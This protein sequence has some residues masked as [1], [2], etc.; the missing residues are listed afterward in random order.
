MIGCRDFQLIL[1][2]YLRKKCSARRRGF[3]RTQK[4]RKLQSTSFNERTRFGK[5]S[6]RIHV[7]T[8]IERILWSLYGADGEW[9]LCTWCALHVRAA[10]PDGLMQQLRVPHAVRCAIWGDY[11]RQMVTNRE[12]F[13]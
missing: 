9:W 2:V 7:P 3:L 4:R 12:G 13:G 11:G 1:G 8:F 6:F 5:E 10:H